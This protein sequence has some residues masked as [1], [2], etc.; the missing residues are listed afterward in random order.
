M[1]DDA[2]GVAYLTHQGVNSRT[3]QATGPKILGTS[4]EPG[5]ANYE[6]SSQLPKNP[7][8]IMCCEAQYGSRQ[9]TR[10]D[11]K[12]LSKQLIDFEN[13]INP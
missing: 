4:H 2:V 6:L 10:L 7:I 1:G 12:G 13:R 5:W 3:L 9:I 11:A 8:Q